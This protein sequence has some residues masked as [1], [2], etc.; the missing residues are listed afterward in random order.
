MNEHE[1]SSVD[2]NN[3]KKAAGFASEAISARKKIDKEINTDRTSPLADQLHKEFVGEYR[4]NLHQKNKNVEA[5]SRKYEKKQ[6]N[7]AGPEL[8]NQ[9]QGQGGPSAKQHP[10]LPIS[11]GIADNFKIPEDFDLEK[12]SELSQDL[13]LQN[14]L[15]SKLTI[16]EEIRKKKLELT[17]KLE[18]K[19]KPRSRPLPKPPSPM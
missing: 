15:R 17:R 8:S 10:E 18:L 2:S 6:N 19:Q 5:I 4:T 1:K 9:A 11:E 12:V 14:K 13:K 3:H 16:S 7:K